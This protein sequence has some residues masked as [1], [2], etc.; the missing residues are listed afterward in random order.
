MGYEGA[1]DIIH[2]P[3]KKK[4]GQHKLSDDQHAYNKLLRGLRGVGERANALLTVT[5]KA[6]RRVSDR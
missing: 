5:F 2:V 1:A 6:L 4:A 3:I